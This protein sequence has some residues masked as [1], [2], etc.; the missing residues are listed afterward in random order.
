MSS[1][2]I[3]DIRFLPLAGV[4]VGLALLPEAA[5]AQTRTQSNECAIYGSGY[6]AIQGTGSCVRIGGRVRV[7]GGAA[8]GGRSN[9]AGGALGFAGDGMRDG[10]SRAHMRLEGPLGG[11]R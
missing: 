1:N 7:E 6:V 8:F 4:I 5:A 9:N 2:C 3:L 11:R 10:P